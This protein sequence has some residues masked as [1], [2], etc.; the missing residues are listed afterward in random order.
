MC[1]FSLC[2]VSKG[3]KFVK[4]VWCAKMANKSVVCCCC[5][6]IQIGQRWLQM[7]LNE[8][9]LW[10]WDQW[11]MQSDCW[12]KVATRAIDNHYQQLVQLQLVLSIDNS[13]LLW[14]SNC[15]SAKFLFP[16]CV[17]VWCMYVYTGIQVVLWQW[18]LC[19]DYFQ[20]SLCFLM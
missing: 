11:G 20:S 18:H 7:L 13:S 4:I 16:T 3:S 14:S 10:Q 6:Q 15:P 17:F 12:R 5:R 8:S 2:E 1:G 19:W 9:E